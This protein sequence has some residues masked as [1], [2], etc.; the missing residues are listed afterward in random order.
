MLARMIMVRV[1]VAATAMPKVAVL[2]V[3]VVVV[4]AGGGGGGSRG[5][6]SKAEVL[7]CVERV[8]SFAG[9]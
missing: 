1:M 7:S 2:V 9:A 4:V 8:G 3:E 5:T 6:R